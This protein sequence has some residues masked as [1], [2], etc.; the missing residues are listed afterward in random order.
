[1][2]DK[3]IIKVNNFLKGNML[4][5]GFKLNFLSE[6]TNNN[7]LA[8]INPNDKHLMYFL[9]YYEPTKKQLKKLGLI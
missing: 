2:E 7:H 6:S 5:R 8:E 1:M 9:K 3:Y 4:N